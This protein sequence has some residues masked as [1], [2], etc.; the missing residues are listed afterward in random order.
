MLV[1]L[2]EIL[3]QYV[4]SDKAVGAFN[5]TTFC[6]AAPV[7]TAAEK[8]NAPVIVQVGGFATRYMDLDLWGPM[9]TTMARRA[10]VPVCKIGRAH[11]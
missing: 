5:V 9:L 3:A 11:V 4:D 10:K 8:R 7:I 2:K 1:T 6:D